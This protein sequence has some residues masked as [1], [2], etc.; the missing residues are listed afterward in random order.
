MAEWRATLQ[1]GLGLDASPFA[2]RFA[3]H[4]PRVFF[5]IPAAAQRNAMAEALRRFLASPWG[6]LFPPTKPLDS[7]SQGVD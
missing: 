5:V 7:E 3:R 1:D 2:L 4:S 6:A